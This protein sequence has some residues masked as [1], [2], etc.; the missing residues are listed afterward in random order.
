MV[1]FCGTLNPNSSASVSWYFAYHAG[2]SCAGGSTTPVEEAE[3]TAIEVT[4]EV[5]E[6]QPDTEYTYCLVVSNSNGKAFGQ[7]LKFETKPAPLSE[8]EA[9]I[10]EECG[11]LVQPAV[12]HSGVAQPDLVQPGIV[13]FCGT[14]NPNSSASVSW[15]FAYNAGAS[16]AGGSTT[17]VEEAEE[18]ADIKVSSQVEELQPGT[19]YTYCLV[20]INSNGKAFGQG[21][22]FETEP[23]PVSEPP[24]SEVQTEPAVQTATG[25]VLKGKLNPESSPT[26]YY[27]IYKEAGTAECEDL[28]GCGPHTVLGGPIT[29]D[30]Q[31]EVQP[32]EVTGLT[33]ETTYAYWLM[34]RN[35]HGIVRGNGRTFTVGSP[36]STP[37][38]PTWPVQGGEPPPPP[39]A[40]PGA[41]PGTIVPE[42]SNSVPAIVTNALTAGILKAPTT[43]LTSAQKLA[44]ALKLCHKKPKRQRASCTK[45]AEKKYAMTAK[46]SSAKQ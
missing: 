17:P 44:N 31:Q 30:T 41:G 3:G 43:V 10:T 12:A 46:W 13:R 11:G 28:E 21:L 6:L 26:S 35:A 24:P 14:L 7:Q 18:G 25:F 42:L 4:S 8:P 32:A 40:T 9:P 5:E 23:A 45:H 22:K 27:F 34:A 16:C 2:A 29:G 36:P 20:A 33:A 15:Y 38:P 1:Q 19:E 39:T 37:S